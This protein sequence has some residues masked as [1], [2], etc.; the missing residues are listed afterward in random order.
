VTRDE[1]TIVV[2]TCAAR[3]DAGRALLAQI[4]ADGKAEQTLVVSDGPTP[5]ETRAPVHAS[6]TREGQAKAYWRALALG[7]QT[8]QGRGHRS[9]L[10]LEDDV[11][12]CRNALSFI[13]LAEL[14]ARYQF[15]SWFDGHAVP[16]GAP[17]GFYP[18][19]TQAFACLQAIS[20]PIASAARL[21][22]SARVS[23]WPEANRGDLLA[24][25]ILAPGRYAV[26][27]PNL[28]QHCGVDSLCHPG[29]ALSGTR[30]AR[31]YAGSSFDALSLITAR[32]DTESSRGKSV[33][34]INP[35]DVDSC[36]ATRPARRRTIGGTHS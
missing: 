27:V 3:R 12:L 30:L 8:A 23:R 11:E 19:P 36:A 17:A 34:T 20:W 31:N 4:E 18:C 15:V 5:V 35:A 33:S 29:A 21:L 1:Q 24:R 6:H 14:S 10:I 7:L 9:F 2:V 22:Q 26:H 25:N 28:V 32:P 13:A 16:A